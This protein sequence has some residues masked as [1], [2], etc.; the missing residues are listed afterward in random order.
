MNGNEL[1]SLIARTKS[2]SHIAISSVLKQTIIFCQGITALL[3][4]R[5]PPLYKTCPLFFFVFFVAF[6]ELWNHRSKHVN[7]LSCY[8]KSTKWS[9]SKRLLYFGIF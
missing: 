6:F 1:P 3:F 9:R 4:S 7:K 5:Y 2:I 8:K